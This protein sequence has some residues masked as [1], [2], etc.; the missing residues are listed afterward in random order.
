MSASH[1]QVIPRIPRTSYPCWAVVNVHDYEYVDHECHVT[2]STICITFLLFPVLLGFTSGPWV[3][4]DMNDFR[5][6]CHSSKRT[7]RW[8]VLLRRDLIST[9]LNGET[10]RL[11]GLKLKV[12]LSNANPYRVEDENSEGS[13]SEEGLITGRENDEPEI[14][15]EAGKEGVVDGCAE[16]W[17]ILNS[18]RRMYRC[19]QVIGQFRRDL[20]GDLGS[21]Q[22]SA[23]HCSWIKV[24]DVRSPVSRFSFP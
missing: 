1:I 18:K 8:L 13:G 12:T 11:D 3:V 24:P 14:V 7:P 21:Y 4:V 19:G 15:P 20:D 5:A 23:D 9:V 6:R 2:I 22:M 17:N 10:V 16:G